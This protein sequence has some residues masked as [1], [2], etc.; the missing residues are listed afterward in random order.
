MAVRKA[1]VVGDIS[2]AAKEIESLAD[3]ASREII[4]LKNYSPDKY[5]DLYA[6]AD[7]YGTLHGF[8]ENGTEAM[9][10]LCQI[11]TQVDTALA[12]LWTFMTPPEE[13]DG[14]DD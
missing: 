12:D 2:E 8:S 10:A 3:T 13:Y 7:F 9:K 4:A 14:S 1:P 6:K 5:H 11:R